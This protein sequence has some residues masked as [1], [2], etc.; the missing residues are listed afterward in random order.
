[1]SMNRPIACDRAEPLIHAY[2]DGELDLTTALEV[3][4]HLA[5]CDRCRALQADL[6]ALVPA[7]KSG[8]TRHRA[9]PALRRQAIRLGAAGRLG[10][11]GRLA[12]PRWLALAASFLLAVGLSSAFTYLEV[13]PAPDDTLAAE[14]VSS[15]IR[16]LMA[17]HLT[18][19]I[20]S[21]QHTVKPWFDGKLDVAPP[22]VDLAGQGF[23][24]VG[25]R[26]DYIGGR[27][28]AAL[29]YRHGL[30]V[31][32]LFVWPLAPGE[33]AA[34]D[35]NARNGYALLNWQAGG[36]AFWAVSDVNSDALRAFAREI[37]VASPTPEPKT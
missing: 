25:G 2:F 23:P 29:V 37:Q 11:V 15:H 1:M 19:V 20:S 13:A 16:S 31:I 6:A 35:L 33:K 27:S 24:L 7:L 9:P 36:M 22:V 3:E 4:E 5:G 30:H 34:A 28:V 12:A 17:N 26:L 18:D 8:L 10:A 32:N 21:D 14:V